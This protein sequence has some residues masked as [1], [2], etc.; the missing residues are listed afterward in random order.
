MSAPTS[1]SGKPTGSMLDLLNGFVQELL[2]SGAV[3][4]AET[5]AEVVDLVQQSYRLHDS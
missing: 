5:P 4:L 1:I 3:A 2:T